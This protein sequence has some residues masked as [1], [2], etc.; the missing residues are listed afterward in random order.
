MI[1][2]KIKRKRSIFIWIIYFS[3]SPNTYTYIFSMHPTA[4]NHMRLFENIEI[5]TFQFKILYFLC[6][7]V[8]IKFSKY[9][10]CYIHHVKTSHLIHRYMYYITNLFLS[11]H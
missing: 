4:K 5:T 1:I 3:E 9:Q 10:I 8:Y 2:D 7:S 11:Y 6:I